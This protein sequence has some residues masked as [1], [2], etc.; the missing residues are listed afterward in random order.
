M[1]QYA[2][3]TAGHEVLRSGSSR[4]A[5][6][7]EAAADIA[8]DGVVDEIELVRKA[9]FTPEEAR[10]TLSLLRRTGLIQPYYSGPGGESDD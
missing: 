6:M 10:T 8:E 1:A 4:I 3:T 2:I 7:L 9:G 5:E